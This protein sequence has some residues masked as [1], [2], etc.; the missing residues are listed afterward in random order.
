MKVSEFAAQAAMCF[1]QDGH[2]VARMNMTTSAFTTGMTP[3]MNPARTYRRI[4]TPKI[5]NGNGFT[6]YSP[7]PS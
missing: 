6:V 2:S 4:Y 7:G 3:K 1:L 5:M